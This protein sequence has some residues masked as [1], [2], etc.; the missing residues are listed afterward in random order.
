MRALIVAYVA[1]IGK[2]S[3]E[4]PF[5]ELNWFN[6]TGANLN[7]DQLVKLDKIRGFSGGSVLASVQNPERVVLLYESAFQLPDGQWSRVYG[8]ADGHIETATSTKNDFTDWEAE[9][10]DSR[11]KGI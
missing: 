9:H 5:N 2:G 6:T 10:T 8:F 7:P 11:A 3:D 1:D 4:M